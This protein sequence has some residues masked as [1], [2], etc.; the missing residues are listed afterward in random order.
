MMLLLLLPLKK[1]SR[2]CLP[3]NCGDFGGDVEELGSVQARELGK[4]RAVLLEEVL[5]LHLMMMILAILRI[6]LR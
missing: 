5:V 4:R 1:C 2:C 6:L 3:R